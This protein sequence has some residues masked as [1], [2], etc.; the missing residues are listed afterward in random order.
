MKDDLQKLRQQIKECDH[1][2]LKMIAQRMSFAQKIAKI[3]KN[4]D[5]NLRNYNVEK[6]LL[7]S[8][9]ELAMSLNLDPKLIK[10][11]TK[12]LIKHSIEIQKKEIKR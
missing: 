5:L 6:D 10:D 11:L 7:E 3:K 4:Q 1:K 9:L 2:L 12:L 8:N